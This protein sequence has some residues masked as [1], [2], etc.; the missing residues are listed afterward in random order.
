M[1]RYVLHA[2][3]LCPRSSPHRPWAMHAELCRRV[4][5]RQ[6]VGLDFGW[7]KKTDS[8]SLAVRSKP[9]SVHESI[10]AAPRPRMGATRAPPHRCDKC[11]SSAVPYARR[12][13]DRHGVSRITH[14]PKL[15]SGSACTI[16]SRAV[17]AQ[18][19][20]TRKSGSFFVSSHRS[21]HAYTGSKYLIRRI[22]LCAAYV[23]VYTNLQ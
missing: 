5:L 15:S 3:V 10:S 20:P 14:V 19:P 11:C 21:A 1:T 23:Y 17:G 4:M 18:A 16:K 7:K 22:N 12:H 9:M 2:R 13:P 8:T 6:L